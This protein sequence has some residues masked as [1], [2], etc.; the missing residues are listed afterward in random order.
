MS[1]T[2][3]RTIAVAILTASLTAS[4]S[5][6]PDFFRPEVPFPQPYTAKSATVEPTLDPDWWRLFRNRTLTRLVTEANVDNTDIGATIARVRQARASYRIA[7]S[8]LFPQ[9]DA[10]GDVAL[11]HT[12]VKGL[13]ST[14]R[15]TWSVAD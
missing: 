14:T 2:N 15:K 8:S 10:A 7:R 5:L 1:G 3:F 12:D 13:P 11:T 6:T 9:I 4:C